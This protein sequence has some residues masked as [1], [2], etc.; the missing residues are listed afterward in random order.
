MTIGIPL[1]IAASLLPPVHRPQ[2]ITEYEREVIEHGRKR[3]R[4][5]SEADGEQWERM[6]TLEETG[7]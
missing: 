4:E 6:N 2:P 1:L 5:R 3:I 7:P